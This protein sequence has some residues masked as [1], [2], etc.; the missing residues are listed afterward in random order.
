MSFRNNACYDRWWEA[1]K[2]WGQ[3][4][5]EARSFAR[6][7]MDLDVARREP[8]LLGLC[9]F[10]HG[11]AARLRDQD[12]VGRMKPWIGQDIK[13]A[14]ANPTDA[15]LREIG[16][17]CAQLSSTGTISDI[18]YSVLE[19]R[20]SAPSA[21]QAGCER[22][23]ATP[24]PFAYT[25]LLHPM[26]HSLRSASWFDFH[27]LQLNHHF[28]AIRADVPPGLSGGTSHPSMYRWNATDPVERQGP[29]WIDESLPAKSCAGPAIGPLLNIIVLP[30]SA[31]KG[32][33]T[34]RTPRS[35]SSDVALLRPGERRARK[36]ARFLAKKEASPTR[37][38]Q[39]PDPARMQ[40]ALECACVRQTSLRS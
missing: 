9:G 27:H 22:I 14:G 20:L 2:L 34:H 29:L 33:S 21:V 40:S 19:Q 35:R 1:R 39:H 37:L 3:L 10:A 31:S 26:L 5:I 32:N 16:R 7:T 6:Q 13:G 4:I 30:G 24:L 36:Q 11:L 38:S 17:Q 8:L 25:L 15:V 18:R 23:K 28:S 12:E